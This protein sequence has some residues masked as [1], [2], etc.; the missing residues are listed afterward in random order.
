MI[1]R[2]TASRG[3]GGLGVQTNVRARLVQRRTC[4]ATIITSRRTKCVRTATRPASAAQTSGTDGDAAIMTPHNCWLG[5]GRDA[6]SDAVNTD[7]AKPRSQKQ[8]P[9]AV[10][11][12]SHQSGRREARNSDHAIPFHHLRPGAP[13]GS[14]YQPAGIGATS[15]TT[16]A[17]LSWLRV[18]QASAN[19]CS[20]PGEK[21]HRC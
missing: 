20:C 13:Y 3:Y 16:R 2:T 17:P 10:Q 11:P 18:F 7:T 19:D 5:W 21:G 4:A 12:Q 8:S 1:W 15:P 9:E 14:G 6:T